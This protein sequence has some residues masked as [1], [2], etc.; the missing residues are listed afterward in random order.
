[1][2]SVIIPV[3]KS[4]NYLSQCLVNPA[5]WNKLFRRSFKQ[6]MVYISK[7]IKEQMIC[8]LLSL[9]SYLGLS[10][11]D[12]FSNS[13]EELWTQKKAW[14]DKEFPIDSKL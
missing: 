13:P 14:E 6:K 11:I 8:I 12:N 2:V 9:H 4:G 5:T 1:M 7:I 3:Y 10:K